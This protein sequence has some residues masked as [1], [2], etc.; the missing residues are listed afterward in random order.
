MSQIQIAMSGVTAGK[1]GNSKQ[2]PTFTV[3][4]RGRMT[5]A[6]DLDIETTVT[7]KAG[8]YNKSINLNVDTLN[9]NDSD[10]VSFAH[11]DDGIIANVNP[12]IYSKSKLESAGALLKNDYGVIPGDLR[13]ENK[14]LAFGVDAGSA[15]ITELKVDTVKSASNEIDF[16]I[17][18]INLLAGEATATG[19]FGNSFAGIS[20]LRSRGSNDAPINVEDQDCLHTVDFRGF[21]GEGYKSFGG[22]SCKIFS[23]NNQLTGNTYLYSMDAQLKLTTAGLLGPVFIAPL[24]SSAGLTEEEKLAVPQMPGHIVYNKT[25]DKFQGYTKNSGWVDLS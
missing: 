13:V 25:L 11:T 21:Q 14:L 22:I 9:F 4:A 23:Y 2:I 6:A 20:L 15:S 3:D 19:P 12:T 16:K 24:F 17:K 8:N 5:W 10:T 1:Y 18:Q 7:V